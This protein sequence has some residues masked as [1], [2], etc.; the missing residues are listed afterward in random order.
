M[1]VKFVDGDEVIADSSQVS[2]GILAACKEFEAY[3][4]S[5]TASAK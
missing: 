3:V 1:T 4:G 5:R 2:G